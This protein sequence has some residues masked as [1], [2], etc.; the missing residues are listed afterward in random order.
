MPR[1]TP[2]CV[3]FCKDA[4]QLCAERNASCLVEL[5]DSYGE[6]GVREIH[7]RTR[8]P[9]RF[10]G[11]QTG[12]VHQQ[13][14]CPEGD[15]LKLAPPVLIADH[16]VEQPSEFFTS[17]DVGDEGCRLFRSTHRNRRAIRVTVLDRE[18]PETAESIVLAM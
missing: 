6:R 17:V 9:N 7:I 8:E 2:V 18:P 5:G 12:A 4:P 3:I 16:S 10:A 15:R 11:A 13:E 1:W 14:E